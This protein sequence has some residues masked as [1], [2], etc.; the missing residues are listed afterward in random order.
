MTVLSEEKGAVLTSYDL[1]SPITAG[2]VLVDGQIYV[3][4]GDGHVHCLTA[5]KRRSP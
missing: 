2:P 5:K 4:T 1:G 3:G